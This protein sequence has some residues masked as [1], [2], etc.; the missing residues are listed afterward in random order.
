MTSEITAR[1]RCITYCYLCAI[2]WDPGPRQTAFTAFTRLHS[3]SN[4][5][6]PMGKCRRNESMKTED[7]P[8]PAAWT[9]RDLQ[10]LGVTKTDWMGVV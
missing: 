7:A 4:L 1:R 9:Q 8:R 10:K 2:Q 3:R 5:A 6:H